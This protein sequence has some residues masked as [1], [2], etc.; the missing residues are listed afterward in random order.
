MENFSSSAVLSG[1]NGN[2]VFSDQIHGDQ[3]AVVGE[4]DGGKGIFRNTDI[5]KDGLMTCQP[6]VTLVTFMQTACHY[7]LDRFILP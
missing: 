6:G 5:S 4:N 3:I 1:L 7:F 2:M